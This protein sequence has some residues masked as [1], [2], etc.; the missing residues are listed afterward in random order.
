MITN[1]RNWKWFLRVVKD[2][3][4]NLHD[5]LVSGLYVITQEEKNKLLLIFDVNSGFTEIL[6]RLDV[7]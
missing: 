5:K 3:N 2:N 7:V 6:N 1:H 4:T